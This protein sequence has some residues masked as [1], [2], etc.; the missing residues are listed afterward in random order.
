MYNIIIIQIETQM[1][2]GRAFVGSG[3]GPCAGSVAGSWTGSVAGSGAAK[4]SLPKS[5]S[6]DLN[7]LGRDL[8]KLVPN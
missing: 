8:F 7:D 2:F 1:K 4:Q 6:L 5:F 3:A